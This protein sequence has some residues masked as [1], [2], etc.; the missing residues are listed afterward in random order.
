MIQSR[1]EYVCI[2]GKARLKGKFPNS[3]SELQN[4]VFDR[5]VFWKLILGYVRLEVLQGCKR[6]RLEGKH[7][8]EKKDKKLFKV[9]VCLLFSRYRKL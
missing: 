2:V 7:L 8:S 1:I 9:K 4:I 6:K 5:N 3:E